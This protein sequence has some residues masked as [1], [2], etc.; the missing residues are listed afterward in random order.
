MHYDITFVGHMCFDEVTY[1][2]KPGYVAPGSAVLCGAAVA[3]RVGKKVA[4]VT[5]LAKK[6]E[7]IL[8]TLKEIGVHCFVTYSDETSWMYVEHPSDNVDDREMILKHN[9]GQFRMEDFP[10]LTSTFVHLAGI[11]DSEFT[12]EFMKGLKENGHNISVD[13]QSFVRQADPVTR[14]VAYSDDS[15]K[16]EIVSLMSKVKLDVVEGEILTGSNDI[17]TAAKEIASWG[18]PEVLITKGEG[19]MGVINGEVT[20]EKFSNRSVVGRTGRGDTT[21]AAYLSGRLDRN[22]DWSLKFAASLV[23]L[24]MEKVGPYTGNLSDALER[25]KK[26]GRV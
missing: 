3:A 25:M 14:R 15:R 2:N 8:D 5:R 11:S 20:F 1:Y 17:E 10:S 21:F 26:D 16:K 7:H 9:A 19:V 23:S 18:C 12:M 22:P 6:D 13:M 4:L 24:K